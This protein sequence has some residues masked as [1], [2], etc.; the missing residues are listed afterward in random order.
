MENQSM[1]KRI[2]ALRKNKAMTQEQL[3]EKLGVSSQAVSKWENDVSCPDISLLPQLADVLGVTT[4]ELL[5]AK[6]IEPHVVVVDAKDRSKGGADAGKGFTVSYSGD[7][8]KEGVW[9]ALA[10]ILVGLAFLFTR[11]GVLPFGSGMTLLGVIWPAVLIGVGVSWFLKS[12]SPFGL[13]LGALGLYYLLF[14]LGAITYSLSWGIVW[15]VLVILLG[16]TILLDKF[17]PNRHGKWS[18]HVGDRAKSEF[19]DNAGYIDYDS[20]FSEETRKVTAEEFTGADLDVSFGKYTLDLTAIQS[21]RAGAILD[22]D[23]SFGSLEIWLPRTVQVHT[24]SDKAFGSIQMK[25]SADADAPYS[26]DLRGDVSFGSL[27]IRYM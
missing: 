1:G 16:L 12:Y 17:Y 18:Q 3:A 19:S 13:G 21:V 25:G 10:I 8:K 27:E 20:A 14:N 24:N 6:P 26:V 23:V 22:V 9:F 7:N 5:G 4:D 2:M 15:P 11:T